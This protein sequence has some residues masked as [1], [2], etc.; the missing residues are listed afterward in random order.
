MNNLKKDFIK[1]YHDERGVLLLMV[2][3]LLISLGLFVFS[4]LSLNPNAAVVKVGYGD[5]GGYRDGTWVSLIAFPVLALIYGILHNI[6]T[7]RIFHKRGSGMAK[8][9]LISTTLLILGTILVLTRLLGE[10]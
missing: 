4:I 7:I 9:F 10:A 8:F 3:N 1:I 6:L 5:I 2:L